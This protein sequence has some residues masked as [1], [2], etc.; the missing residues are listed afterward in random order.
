MATFTR[1]EDLPITNNF[2]FCKVMSDKKLCK[3]FLETILK[4]EIDHLEEPVSEY[5]ISN[6]TDSKPVRF[7]VYTKDN[8]HTYDIEMQMINTQ[9]I[10][11]RARFYQ[12]ISDVS[13][14]EKSNKYNQLKTNI[15]IFLCPFDIYKR[16]MPQYTFKNLCLEDST[17]EMNDNTIKIFYNF[18]FYDKIE[19]EKIREVMKFFATEQTSGEFSN[20]MQKKLDYARSNLAWRKQ[21]MLINMVEFDATERGIER[22]IDIGIERKAVSTA[23]NMLSEGI[24][25][26][27]IAKC[28]ELP[29]ERVLSLKNEAENKASEH[30]SSES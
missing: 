9:N 30:Q 14:L 22:G 6:T 4:I 11:L 29:L 1:W 5:Y 28:C 2:M 7:D 12:A 3:E 18:K 20:Y 24:A 13:E 16:K 23:R 15:I 21:Y 25:P 26:E 10:P 17:I 19:D 27:I 8:Q